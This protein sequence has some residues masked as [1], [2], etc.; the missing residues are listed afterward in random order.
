MKNKSLLIT[1]DI[2][3]FV[4]LCAV[5]VTPHLINP[6]LDPDAPGRG[7][8]AFT[9]FMRYTHVYGGIAIAVLMFFHILLTAKWFGQ[10]FK[11][12]SKINGRIKF[13]FFLMMILLISMVISI[14]SGII[15]WQRG[16]APTAPLR[17]THELSSWIAFVATG[18]HIGLHMQKFTSFFNKKKG[19]KTTTAN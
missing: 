7:M 2:L 3:L 1:V 11:N 19:C 18:M 15:W 17:S 14:W 12:W 4:A 9:N 16:V 10:T 6:F 13:Q 5:M 8:T